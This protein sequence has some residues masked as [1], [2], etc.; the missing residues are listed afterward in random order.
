[1]CASLLEMD[2][3]K[4]LW[5]IF[6]SDSMVQSFSLK[7]DSYSAGQEIA[8]PYGVHYYHFFQNPIIV[9][10]LEQVQFCFSIIHLGL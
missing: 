9:P 7:V 1:M 2:G 4:A 8:C 3:G 5:T 10:C 6:I